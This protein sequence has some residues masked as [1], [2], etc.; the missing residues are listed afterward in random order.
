M[1]KYVWIAAAA[2]VVITVAILWWADRSSESVPEG[3]RVTMP[4]APLQ[5]RALDGGQ[6]WRPHPDRA[7]LLRGHRLTD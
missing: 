6:P 1:S 2:L 7:G 5:M 4:I 3:R